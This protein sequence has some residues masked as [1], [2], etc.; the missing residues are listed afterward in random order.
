MIS[1]ITGVP[2]KTIRRIK[3]LSLLFFS[4]LLCGN[5]FAQRLSRQDILFIDSLMNRYYAWNDPGAVLLVAY[6]GIPMIRRAYGLANLE[7]NV[8]NRSEFVFP[9]GSLTKQFTAVCI[10]QLAQEGKL[11]LT[12]DIRKYLPWYNTHGRT[13]T[14]EQLLNHTSGIISFSEKQEFITRMMIHQSKYEIAKFFMDDS[15]LFEPGT[16]WSY[17]NS[18]YFLAGMILETVTGQLLG[19]YMQQN[20]FDPLNMTSTFI[21]NHQKLIPMSVTG[22][23]ALSYLDYK[24]AAY[25]SWTWMFGSGDIISNVDD[26]LK[27]DQALYGEKLLK[28]EWLQKLWT[29]Y[30]LPDGTETH[31]G[32]GFL[33][34]H[35]EEVETI[36]HGGGIYGFMSYSVRIP[37]KHLFI[38]VLSNKAVLSPATLTYRIAFRAAGI[39]FKTER[40]QGMNEFDPYEYE[41][42]Y[43]IHRMGTRLAS[44]YNHQQMFR[45]ITVQNDTLYSQTTGTSRD[46]LLPLGNDTYVIRG[47][48]SYIQFKRDQMNDIISLDVLSEP[49]NF[50]PVQTEVKTDIPLPV[51]KSYLSLDP[52]ILKQYTGNYD[53]GDDYFIVVSVQSNH[54]YIQ[55]TGRAKEEIFAE[56]ETRFSLKNADITFE[57]VKNP[58]GIFDKLIM[59]QFGTYI[60]TKIN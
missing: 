36:S 3:Y 5:D 54:I 21:G 46:V 4:L 49:M 16:D 26:L 45:Y 15:L 52:D 2:D 50:G 31:Y 51:E 39:P 8:Q 14:V 27:W 59:Y 6:N 40:I 55:D 22:Y 34:D 23:S 17:S 42:V 60:A 48:N 13:I 44:N 19:D 57:F 32:L 28:K 47:T 30:Q 56:T 58:I 7:L 10:L 37:S 41:G 1:L 20:I 18:G 11:S 12:D 43:A 33:I 53:F 25:F 29:S 9:I 38:C 35:Y 24:R